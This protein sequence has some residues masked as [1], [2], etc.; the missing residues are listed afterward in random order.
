MIFKRK[1]LLFDMSKGMEGSVVIFSR[2]NFSFQIKC[3][4]LLLWIKCR[5]AWMPDMAAV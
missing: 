1:D 5:R 2:L 4:V 3:L